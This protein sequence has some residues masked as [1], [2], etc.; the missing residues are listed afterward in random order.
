MDEHEKHDKKNQQSTNN[1]KLLD[2]ISLS[3]YSPKEEDISK[4]LGTE[5]LIRNSWV[6][7]GIK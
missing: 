4:T 3:G 2:T 5:E 6:N 1:I 7:R